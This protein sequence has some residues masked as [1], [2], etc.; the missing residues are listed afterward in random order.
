MDPQEAYDSALATA[1]E[2]AKGN[3]HVNPYIYLVEV[4]DFGWKDIATRAELVD[5]AAGFIETDR[6]TKEHAT[7]FLQRY[8]PKWL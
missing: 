7:A 5:K 6:K 2:R 8:A 1:R 3:P 4:M